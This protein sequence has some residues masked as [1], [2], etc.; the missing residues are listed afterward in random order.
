MIYVD[1]MKTKQN[2]KLIILAAALLVLLVS[3]SVA[4]AR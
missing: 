2:T 4:F 1:K 3:C